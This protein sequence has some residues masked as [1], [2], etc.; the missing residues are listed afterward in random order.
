MKIVDDRKKKIAYKF[1]RKYTYSTLLVTLKTNQ[2]PKKPKEV[3]KKD[4]QRT[5][6]KI[7]R[8]KRITE[9]I[10][11]VYF[12]ATAVIFVSLFG[13]LQV[14]L[15]AVPKQFEINFIQTIKLEHIFFLKLP[16]EGLYQIIWVHFTNF[17]FSPKGL[18]PREKVIFSKHS[19]LL[20]K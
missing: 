10:S 5:H 1:W 3:K 8:S 2:N 6:L 13:M 17:V 14:K 16:K 4:E 18:H 9:F 7:L 11:H 12:H 20:L 19:E 15:W